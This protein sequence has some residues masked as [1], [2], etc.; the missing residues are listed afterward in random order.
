MVTGSYL[1][2]AMSEETWFILPSIL[3]SYEKVFNSKY[4]DKDR[5]DAI[6]DK[7]K[8]NIADN[9]LLE[10]IGNKAVINM[11]GTLVRKAGF[12]D[13]MCGISGM[14][15]LTN[16]FNQVIDDDEIEHVILNWDSPGG[17]A[18]GTP[19]FAEIVYAARDKKRI[20]SCISGCMCSAAYFIGSAAHEIYATSQINDVGSIGVVMMH[21]DQSQADAESGLKYTYIHAGKHKVDGNP[22]EALSPEVLA[23][24][25][26]KLNYTYGI[27]IDSVAKYRGVTTDMISEYAEGKVF[28]AGQV[29]GTPLLDGI[30]TLNEILRS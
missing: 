15:S 14:D 30:A 21:V 10:I 7:S 28:K 11:E 23:G 29:V 5:F 16:L 2:N 3:K 17:S 9:P 8:D 20:T 24:L 6:I 4:I 18:V 1:L 26:D 19:E 13:A 27:F 25:Q 12:L 22:H